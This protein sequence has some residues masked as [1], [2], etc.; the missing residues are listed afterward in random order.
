MAEATDPKKEAFD[1][2]VSL[3]DI[4]GFDLAGIEAR[5]IGDILPKMF[6]QFTCTQ[7]DLKE[8]GGD[9]KGFVM[10]MGWRV[11]GVE[12]V[13]DKEFLGMGGDEASLVGKTHRE[14][15]IINNPEG[16]EYAKGHLEE[17]YGKNKANGPFKALIDGVVGM[18]CQAVIAHRKD[19]NDS[20]KVYSGL[21]KIKMLTD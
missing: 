18:R 19:K 17:Y 8:M 13:T 2:T 3:A 11:D 15:R 1:N 4:A 12:K 14:T 16:L 21:T 6:A 5:K 10:E 20:D 7:A 9:K